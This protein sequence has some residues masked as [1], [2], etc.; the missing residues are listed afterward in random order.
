[1]T[2][3][4]WDLLVGVCE[5]RCIWMLL[6]NIL[7]H[8]LLEVKDNLRIMLGQ[9]VSKAPNLELTSTFRTIIYSFQIL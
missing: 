6:C 3:L 2:F 7:I 9:A 1:M 4:D 8:H 5:W